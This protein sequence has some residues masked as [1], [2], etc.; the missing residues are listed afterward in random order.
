MRR[1]IAIRAMRCFTTT[2]LTAFAVGLFASASW[3][4]EDMRYHDLTTNVSTLELG[5]FYNSDD[6]F[7]FGD[8]TGLEDDS[9]SILGNFD[10]RRRSAFDA[11]RAYYYRIRGLNLGLDSRTIDAEYQRPGLFGVSLFYDE[12]PKY[13]TDTAQTFMSNAG[14][15]FLTLPSTCG[16]ADVPPGFPVGSS[17]PDPACFYGNEIDHKRRTAGGE[18]SLILPNNFDFDA[19]YQRQRKK[20]EKLTSTMIGNSWGGGGSQI[21]PEPLKYT[22]HQIDSHLRYTADDFQLQLQYYAS[23]FYNDLNGLAWQ[24]PRN[25]GVIGV[26]F[27]DGG[28]GQKASMPDNWF[29]QVTASGGLDL[30]ANSRVMLNAAFGWGTQ[31]D[32]FLP[33]TNNPNISA[34]PGLPLGLRLPRPNLDGKLETRLVTARFVS[35]PLPKLGINIAYRWNERDNDSP[36]D[37]YFRIVADSGD[38]DP[39]DARVNRPYSFEQHKVD[40]DVSYQ[41]YKRTKLTLMYEWD[42]TTRNLQE[43]HEN[44]EHSVGGKLVSRPNQYVNLGA[45]YER[46]YR[47]RSTYDCVKPHIAGLPPG[48]VVNPGC[49]HAVGSGEDFENSPQLRKYYMANRRRNDSHAWLTIT[50]LDNLSIGSHLKFIDDDYYKT[51]FGV[52]GYRLLSTGLDLSYAATDALNFHTFYTHDKSRTEMDSTSSSTSF[53]PANYWSSRDKDT[54]NTVGAGIDFDVIPDRLSVGFEYL[55]AKSKGRIKT[56]K[57]VGGSV[58]PLFPDNET[59]LHDVSVRGNLQITRNLSMRLG[60]LFEKFNSEDWAIQAMCPTCL[61]TNNAVIASGERPPAYDAHVV[62]L[63]MIY[64]FW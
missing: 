50:P 3:S 31:R 20:G 8:F 55:F 49:P 60:Y 45:R 44:N 46:S 61:S 22:T 4:E 10:L 59:E 64:R 27:D 39:D 28:V 51:T 15:S 33:Y 1:E 40:A 47:D 35:N 19:S 32:D 21:V 12:I 26:G 48:T 17:S 57:D 34:D 14:A 54:T 37:T 6:D 42:R 38:Q 63:S 24:D 56:I 7:K 52:T 53:N 41:I 58:S 62:S 30:P 13:Q 43:V 9:W 5:T 23:G 36:I 25:S 16:P 18:F 2:L 11:E 29:H